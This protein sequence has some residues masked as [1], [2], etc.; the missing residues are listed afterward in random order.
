MVKG[1]AFRYF[2]LKVVFTFVGSLF[3]FGVHTAV[4]NLTFS[5]DSS[6]YLQRFRENLASVRGAFEIDTRGAI[7]I[8][9]AV[10]TVST[11]CRSLVSVSALPGIWQ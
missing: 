4:A 1:C 3:L 10:F 6:W 5:L 2:L 7:T 11:M 8:D 9:S